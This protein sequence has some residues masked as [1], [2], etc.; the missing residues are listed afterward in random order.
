MAMTETPTLVSTIFLGKLAP[1]SHEPG[2]PVQA[3]R[4]TTR[5]DGGRK[6]CPIKKTGK[7]TNWPGYRITNRLKIGT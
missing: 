6:V 4:Y 5:G 3:L 2:E 7:V 1:I